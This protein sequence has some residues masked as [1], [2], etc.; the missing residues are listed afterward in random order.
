[1]KYDVGDILYLLSRKNNKIVP[2]RVEAIITVKKISGEEITHEL[3]VQGL[4]R[5]TILEQLDVIPF[6]NV[7]D[8]RSH[9][10]NVLQQKIDSE[11]STVTAAA[12]DAWPSG[13]KDSKLSSLETEQKKVKDLPSVGYVEET[14]QV[15][16]PNGRTANVILPKELV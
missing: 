11:I 14:M 6:D 1:M 16:L 4:D 15:E 10:L 9:M 13:S 3:S 7:S 5:M 2:S 12:A 8:L